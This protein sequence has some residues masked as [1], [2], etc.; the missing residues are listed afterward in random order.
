MFFIIFPYLTVPFIADVKSSFD[1]RPYV[2][3]I[4]S[5][6]L[7]RLKAADIDQEVKERAISCMYVNHY[8]LL[9]LM[10]TRFIPYHKRY[11]QSKAG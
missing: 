3:D 1:Y 10:L 7:M 11:I 9:K 8:Q 4:Y 2:R 5:C 6:T